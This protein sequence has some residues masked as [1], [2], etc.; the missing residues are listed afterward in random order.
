MPTRSDDDAVL[1]DREITFTRLLEAPRELVWRVWT[2]DAHVLQWWGP[3]GFTTTTRDKD[4]R[5]GGRWRFVMHGPDGHDYENL[6]RYLE[7]KEPSLLS[8]EHGGDA[9]GGEGVEPVRFRVTVTFEEAGPERTKLTMSSTF[10]S[11]KARDHVISKY[12]ALEGGKQTLGRLV[13]YL[14]A[15]RAAAPGGDAPLV[16]R[17]VVRAPRETV[18]RAWTER[19]ELRQWAACTLDLAPGGTFRYLM[20]GPGMDA[21]GKWTFREIDPRRR[22]AFTVSFTDE[23]GRDVKGPH[24]DAQPLRMLSIV[25]FEDHAGIGRGTVVTLTFSALDATPAE[26]ATFDAS[27]DAMRAGWAGMFAKLDRFV[28]RDVE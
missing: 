12:G 11:Q 13:E 10:P 9:G 1:S 17:H 20:Q 3:T 5:T 22:L 16:V 21:W 24:L 4:V 26:R 2:E 25:T 28:A 27:H 14:A 7:V 8:Y 6:V 15:Q 23:D 18:W 19:E